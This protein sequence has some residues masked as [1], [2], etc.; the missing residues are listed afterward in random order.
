MTDFL[1][2]NQLS[3]LC[4]LISIDLTFFIAW[5]FEKRRL[6]QLDIKAFLRQCRRTESWNDRSELKLCQ[7]MLHVDQDDLHNADIFKLYRIR[8]SMR[9]YLYIH[10]FGHDRI[11]P[12]GRIERLLQDW[13]DRLRYRRETAVRHKKKT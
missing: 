11:G 1:V 7:W 10:R 9:D 2:D 13:A 12:P 5:Y 3:I 6:L 4:T 8:R